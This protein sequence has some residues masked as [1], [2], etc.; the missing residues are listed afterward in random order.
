MRL[1][2]ETTT[3]RFRHFL[4]ENNLSIQLLAAIN[5]LLDLLLYGE[6]KQVSCLGVFY[7]DQI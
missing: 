1:S 3:L 4:E 5:A 7:K 6:P 2:D